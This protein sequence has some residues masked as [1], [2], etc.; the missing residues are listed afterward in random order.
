M[1]TIT[2]ELERPEYPVSLVSV[3]IRYSLESDSNG[4]EGS[5]YFQS[6]NYLN[7]DSSTVNGKDIE[8]TEEEEQIIYNR[9]TE[10]L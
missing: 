10:N 7:L 9:I 2:V 3:D 4:M 8:L 1:N 6:F 5:P